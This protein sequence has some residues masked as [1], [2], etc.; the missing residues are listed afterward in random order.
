MIEGKQER[1]EK[2]FLSRKKGGCANSREEGH[3]LGTF[4]EF[5]CLVILSV[6]LPKQSIYSTKRITAQIKDGMLCFLLRHT[7]CLLKSK[8][9]FTL[10]QL[11]DMQFVSIILKCRKSQH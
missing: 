7:L 1:Y 11:T 6:H 10:L 2:L 5:S 9:K 8:S 3:V 4:F